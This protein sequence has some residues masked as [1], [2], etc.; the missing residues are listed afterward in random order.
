MQ[1]PDTISGNSGIQHPIYS[2]IWFINLVQTN[3]VNTEVGHPKS[4]CLLRIELSTVSQHLHSSTA[5]VF[6]L[7]TLFALVTLK[8][9]LLFCMW[10]YFFFSSLFLFL[11]IFV[12]FDFL[13]SSSFHLHPLFKKYGFTFEFVGDLLW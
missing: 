6:T 1:F 2:I 4:D 11:C 8:F 5:D 12:S 10:F 3:H 7:Y 9:S 13:N